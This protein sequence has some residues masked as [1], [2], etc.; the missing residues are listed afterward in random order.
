MNEYICVMQDLGDPKDEEASRW[1][2]H[3]DA[4][5][6]DHAQEQALDGYGA[7]VIAVYQRVR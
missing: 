7:K 6:A 5:D 4:N 2:F 1:N 3:C